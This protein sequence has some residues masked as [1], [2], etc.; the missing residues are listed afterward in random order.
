MANGTHTPYTPPIFQPSTLQVT[1]NCLLF[2]SLSLS[3]VTALAG[4][5]ALQWVSKYDVLT[6]RMGASPQDRAIRRHYR[7]IGTLTW[8]M[9]EVISALPIA[10]N[11]AVM[12]FF[13]GITVWMWELRRSVSVIVLAGAAVAAAFYVITASLAVWFPSS[14]FRTPLSEWIY[15]TCHTLILL[16]WKL[17][18]PDGTNEGSMGSHLTESG[19]SFITK[20]SQHLQRHFSQRNLENRDDKYIM[21]N[22]DLKL[23]S[24]A[25]LAKYITIS[26][27]SYLRLHLLVRELSIFTSEHLASRSIRDIP[28]E[29]IFG[30]I[31]KRFA[32]NAQNRDLGAT[33]IPDLVA[34]LQC[35][36]KLRIKSSSNEAVTAPVHEISSKELS[37]ERFRQ[38]SEVYANIQHIITRNIR[39]S[40][41]PLIYKPYR[42][43][44][45]YTEHSVRPSDL[46]SL[47][48]RRIAYLNVARMVTKSPTKLLEVWSNITTLEQEEQICDYLIGEILPTLGSWGFEETQVQIDNLVCLL[49]LRRP[50]VLEEPIEV[51]DNYPS[52]FGGKL[53]IQYPSPAIHRLRCAN[54]M[55]QSLDHPQIHTILEALLKAHRVYPKLQLRWRFVASQEEELSA[56]LLVDAADKGRLANALANHKQGLYLVQ[57]LRPFDELITKLRAEDSSDKHQKI[58]TVRELACRDFCMH[59]F[60]GPAKFTKYT[61]H[62]MP[63]INDRSLRLIGCVVPRGLNYILSRARHRLGD[64]DCDYLSF[65]VSEY[66][67]G[68]HPS[69][70][71]S[72]IWQLRAML[73]REFHPD[74]TYSLMQSALMH[75]PELV[76]ILLFSN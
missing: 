38:P 23:D 35:F 12:L 34:M 72:T 30:A 9:D 47:A 6:K 64:E 7:F 19:Q 42:Y 67:C 16:V 62:N 60:P 63:Y 39:T 8:T 69:I 28:W 74:V 68:D 43:S 41:A 31:G 61:S 32:Q 44:L 53:I 37:T 2:A 25:W 52:I 29:M 70:E 26:D 59:D 33:D 21:G 48:R 65:H 4:V 66:C 71:T 14:P 56:L 5:L 75:L 24:L 1:V 49:R 45:P 58:E 11:L 76:R 57:H 10:L 22:T 3:L 15:Y 36:Q 40:K 73:W 54:W 18:A 17:P 51:V 27:A 50:L 46:E 13:S 55:Q 20:V